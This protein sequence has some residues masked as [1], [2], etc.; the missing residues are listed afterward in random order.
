MKVKSYCIFARNKETGELLGLV[1][2]SFSMSWEKLWVKLYKSSEYPIEYLH[3]HVE[4]YQL[5][6]PTFDI[7]LTRI[8]SKKCPVIIYWDDY[9]DQLKEYGSVEKYRQ[10]N[11]PFSIK[12]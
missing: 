5:K 8:G 11:R 2:N 7:F 1:E 12:P 6:S 4:V 10:R 9:Y 3:N